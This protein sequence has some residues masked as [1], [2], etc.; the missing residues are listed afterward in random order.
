MSGN[1]QAI[2]KPDAQTIVGRNRELQLILDCLNQFDSTGTSLVLIEGPAGVGKT[3]LIREA[4]NHYSYRKCFKLYGKFE[5]HRENAPYSAFR[6]AFSSWAQQILLL[7]DDEFDLLKENSTSALQTNITAVT[8]VFTEL[9]VFFS[10]KNSGR[11]TYPAHPHQIKAR[12]FYFLKKFIRSI[13]GQGYQIIIFL[14]D[15]QWCDKASFVLLEELLKGNDINGLKFIAASRGTEDSLPAAIPYSKAFRSRKNVTYLHL[16]PLKRASVGAMVPSHWIFSKKNLADFQ[17]Y[18]WIESSGN[19]FR[20]SEILKTIQRDEQ[21]EA[22]I[23]DPAFWERLPRMAKTEDSLIFIQGQLRKLPFHQLQV[24]AT[25]SC[26]GY[27][28]NSELL[29]EVINLP[30]R[31]IE[32]HLAELIKMDLLIKKRNIFLFTH[33]TIFSAANSL[34]SN[35][36]KWVVH[37]RTAL[38]ML[39]K[40]GSYENQEFF[41]AVN[42]LNKAHE[43]AGSTRVYSE[44]HILLNIQAAKLAITST[45]FE[46]AQNYYAFADHLFSG[47]HTAIQISDPKLL[48]LFNIREIDN[49]TLRFHIRYGYAE[50]SFLLLQFEA[51]LNF[52]SQALEMNCT[53]HQRLQATLIKMMICSALI[54]QKNVP[55][56][57]EDGFRS[58]KKTLAE[59][60]I[61][62][63]EDL[64]MIKKES[65]MD[66]KVLTKK[67]ADLNFNGGFSKLVNPNQEYQDLMNLVATSMTFLY[68][69]DPYKNLYMVSKTLLLSLEKGFAP[70]TPVLFSA[71]FFTAFFSDENRS[72]AHFLGRLSLEMIQKEPFKRYSYMVH[73]VAILNF[74]PWENHYKACVNKLKEG[75]Q[76]ATEAGDS[77]YAS[78]CHTIVRVLD[79]YRGKNLLKHLEDSAKNE[80]DHHVFF[81]SGTDNT[82]SKHLTGQS[83]GFK[84]G[85]FVFPEEILIESEHNLTS[86]YNYLLALE[87]LNYIGNFND[88]AVLAA[89]SCDGLE[90]VGKGFQIEVEHFFFFSLSLL[91]AAYHDPIQLPEVLRKV[92]P[93][94]EELK[95]LA[96]FKSGNYLHKVYLIEAEIAK[97]KADFEQATQLY[98]LAITE[99]KE[100]EFVH[101]A[102]IA[103]ERAFEYYRDKDRMRQARFYLNRSLKLYTAWGATAKVEQLKDLYPLIINRKPKSPSYAHSR[104]HFRVIRDIM[105][106]TV[107]GKEISL[108]ELAG[109]LVNL[110]LK[111]RNAGKA[112]ILLFQENSWNIVALAPPSGSF[113]NKALHELKEEL[114]VSILNYCINK[115]EKYILQDFSEDSLFSADPYLIKEQLQNLCIFPI[116]QSEETIGLIYL[117]NCP[118]LSETEKDLFLITVE[119]I[120]TTFANAVY[121]HNN[122]LLNKELELQDKNRIAA[123]IESQEKERQRIARDLHDSLG[124]ILAL[125]KINLTRINAENLEPESRILL[126]QVSDL[127]DESCR[128]VRNIS[129]DLMPPDL[130]NLSLTEVLENLINK[131]RHIYGGTY[132]FHAHDLKQDLSPACKFTLYRVL[133]EILQNILKHASASKVD[134]TLMQ[135]DDFT[136]LLVEDNGKGFDTSMTNL[137]IGL[138]N[139]HSRVKILHGYFDIDSSINNGTVFNISIPLSV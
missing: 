67:V 118:V 13:T 16:K 124:Q 139:I 29:K 45:A 90:Y 136:N 107:P 53:R 50:T 110:I 80:K 59:F 105:S 55:H 128:E 18:L 4:L 62:I 93:K 138:K 32:L 41:R 12:F 25:A 44:E 91:K 35:A 19:P 83:E 28:F 58:L 108:T 94:L 42:H 72:L 30:P 89:E 38:F 122:R 86:R 101:H 40:M 47:R 1:L 70:V 98:E 76:Q 7:S 31:E 88:A 11:N 73:Y 24:I 22:N 54:H 34:L 10:R 129:H 68:Y 82:I 131:T 37:Q 15:I 57:L 71:S 46:V 14:D 75:A 5:N 63:P 20:I 21:T 137:G 85:E 97:C 78:F 104:Q 120:S 61:F 60:E 125:S 92:Q 103:A 64:E 43:L 66:C 100:Q 52:I 84:K 77:H 33:D 51:A 117:E 121:Y 134:I 27:S 74:Y 69:M 102:A 79:S 56:I 99:A 127:I 87:K 6:Q 49:E 119:L 135:N 81:I 106:Q 2:S 126:S 39:N 116:K 9:E 114:P 3:T 48:D 115:G 111:E 109:D 26:L 123:V 112:A 8:S 132:S 17:N 65:A 23:D 36:E 113:E 133:Q 96:S 130:E 95:R